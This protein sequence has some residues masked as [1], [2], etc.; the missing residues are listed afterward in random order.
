MNRRDLFA[1]LA[2]TAVAGQAFTAEPALAAAPAESEP[3]MGSRVFDWNSIPVHPNAHGSVRQFFNTRTVS[4]EHFEL[5]V[6]TLDPGMMP[7]PPHRHPN[8]EMMII[9]EGTLAALQNGKWTTV[10]PGSVIFNASNQLHGLKN[11]GKVPAVYHVLNWKTAAT[12]SA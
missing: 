11:V 1:A 5:H 10:G 9:R 2:A 7:H 4:L 8:E 3:V 12:P 6:T